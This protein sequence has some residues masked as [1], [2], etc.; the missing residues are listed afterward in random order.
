MNSFAQ[1]MKSKYL[2]KIAYIRKLPSGK[3]RVFSE[4][5][6]NLGTFDSHDAAAKHLGEIEFF[7]HKHASKEEP[8][9]Y[10]S[11]LRRLNKEGDDH[12][13]KC[14]LSAFKNAFDKLVLDGDTEPAEKALPIAQFILA[15]EYE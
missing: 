8:E 5:G 15:R 4:K 13:T 7:K 3:Y 1:A 6:K 2:D 11:T 12:A 14:F 10:S 9:T